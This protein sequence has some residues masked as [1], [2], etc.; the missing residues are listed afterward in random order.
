MANKPAPT[1]NDADVN[2]TVPFSV[3]ASTP[4]TNQPVVTHAG[5]PSTRGRWALTSIAAA[6]LLIIGLL[7]GML[8][9]QQMDRP[10]MHNE[11]SPARALIQ[12]QHQSQIQGAQQRL[13]ERLKE[14][15][16][17]QL[18]PGNSGKVTPSPKVSTPPQNNG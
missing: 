7:G 12:K 15:H 18:L 13:K 9:G 2:E 3:S 8:I 1:E 17:R 16:D 4:Y 11:G 6:G 10:G 14:R 5:P